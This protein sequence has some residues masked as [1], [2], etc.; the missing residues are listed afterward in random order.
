MTWGQQASST[1]HRRYMQPVK[2]RQRCWCGCKQRAT[3][4]GFANGL[5]LMQPVCELAARRWVR[6]GWVRRTAHT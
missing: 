1:K 6:S 5:C 3:H 4:A 2:T